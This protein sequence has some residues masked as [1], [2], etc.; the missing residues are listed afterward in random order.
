MAWLPLP[1]LGTSAGVFGDDEARHGRAAPAV[2]SRNVEGRRAQQRRR[3]DLRD[4]RFAHGARA[5]L[6]RRLGRL[7]EAQASY[8]RAL[9]LT[10]QAPERRFIEKRLAE[11]S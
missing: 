7:K 6:C 4:Y 1:R 8:K 5:D 9:E 11:L 10:R 3:G 2:I